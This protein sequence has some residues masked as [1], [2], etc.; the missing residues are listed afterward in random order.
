MKGISSAA[1]KRLLDYD[2]PGNV[3]ELENTIERAMALAQF[4][5]IGVED[6]PEKIQSH[7]STQLVISGSNPEELVSLEEL[8][9]R[10]ILR[11]LSAVSGNKTQA[12]KVLEL[13]RRTLYRKLD[14]YERADRVGD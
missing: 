9:K 2:W 6:L 14:G 11:V 5:E 13:D 8:E 1:A 3:R 7:Q 10:Y 4:D 12:A